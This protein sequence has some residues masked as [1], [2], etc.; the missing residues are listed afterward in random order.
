VVKPVAERL[1]KAGHEVS[2]LVDEPGAE[3]PV[4]E[5]INGVRVV[6]WPTRVPGGAYH[7]PKRRSRLASAL[8]EVAER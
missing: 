6:R 5:E 4:E 2:V 1:A 7:V 3:E 8:Q